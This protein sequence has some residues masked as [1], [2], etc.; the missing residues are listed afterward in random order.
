MFCWPK[1]ELVAELVEFEIWNFIEFSINKYYLEFNIS[2]TVS[3]I[4]KNHL[5]KIL[6][7]PRLPKAC[8]DLPFFF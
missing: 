3:L 2:C 6:L 1:Y 8:L 7:I 5:H 4:F